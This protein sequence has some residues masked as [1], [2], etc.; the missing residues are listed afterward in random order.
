M[1][2]LKQKPV[3]PGLF[4]RR[5]RRQR[6]RTLERLVR[7]NFKVKKGCDENGRVR[8]DRRSV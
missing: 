3:P 6:F 8:K 2:K 5:E 4:P 1:Q 7:L